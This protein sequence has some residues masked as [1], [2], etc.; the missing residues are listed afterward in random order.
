MR[1]R[2]TSSR[3]P[4]TQTRPQIPALI[5]KH[6]PVRMDPGHQKYIINS[7]SN[8]HSEMVSPKRRKSPSSRRAHIIP[9]QPESSSAFSAKSKSKSFKSSIKKLPLCDNQNNSQDFDNL[10][11]I[12]LSKAAM[13]PLSQA[14]ESFFKHHFNAKQVIVYQEIPNLQLLYSSALGIKM[15]HGSGLVGYTFFSR[16]I[17]RSQ[18]GALHPSFLPTVDSEICPNNSPIL[19]FPL[20]DWKN[21]VTYI[22]EIIRPT[23]APEFTPEDEEFVEWFTKKFKVLSRWLKPSSQPDQITTELLQFNKLDQFLRKVQTT[24]SELFQCRTFEIWKQDLTTDTLLRYNTDTSSNIEIINQNGAGIVGDC[25][26]RGQLVNVVLNKF[27][28]SYNSSIDGEENEAV[29]CLPVSESDGKR[30][31]ALVLRGPQSDS[32]FTKDDEEMLRRYAPIIL[33]GLSNSESLTV[34][35]RE[36]Q[37]SRIER[38]GLGA[39]LEVVEIISSQLDTEKLTDVIMEKGRLLTDADRCSLFLV[40]EQ[41]DRLITYLHQ[42]LENS[43]DL[44]IN[45]GIAGKTVM[46][47]KIFNIPDVYETDFFDSTT[48]R[49]SGYRTKS[50][51]S[52]PIYNNRGEVIGVTEMVNKKDDKPFTQ[53]DTKLIQIFNVFCGI[54]L[55]NARLYKESIEMSHEIRSFFD[56]AFAISHSNKSVQRVISDILQNAKNTIGASNASIFVLDDGSNSQNL[57]TFISDNELM[58][59]SIPLNKGIASMCVKTKE[60]YIVNDCYKSPLFNRTIDHITQFKSQSILA[61]PILSTE[62]KVLGV[63]EIVNKQK[64][65]F[66]KKDMLMLQAFSA[67][68]AIALENSRL[69]DIAQL[70]DAEIEMKKWISFNERSRTE[71]P[72]NLELN[73]EEKKKVISLNCFAVDF[74]GIGHFKELFYFFNM[75]KLLE[76]FKIT[77]ERFF[78]F[79]FVISSTYNQVPYHNWTHA[80]DVSQYVTYE[81][82]TAGLDKVFTSFELFGLLTAAICHD[83]NHEGLNNIYNVKA[84]T[85]FGILFKDQSV[86]EMHHITVAIPIITRDDINL[87]HSLDSDETKKMWNLFVK[88]I[89]ATDMAKHF[90]LVKQCQALNDEG[91]WSLEEPENR[92]LALQLLIK[93][94]DI[95]NVSRPFE[96]ANKWCDILNNEFFR[97]GDL[98]K[99]SGIGLTSPLNDR[100]H[101]DKPKSQIG[102]YNFICL[103]LYQV[104]ALIFPPLQVNVD[105]LKSNLEVWKSMVQQQPETEEKK[106]GNQQQKN[107]EKKEGNQ[108]QKN[109][110]SKP[111]KKDESDKK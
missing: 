84:E 86:M 22:I 51:L 90:A 9:P 91:K 66:I 71:I 54:S 64:G 58:P 31:F 102:F 59:P 48:D 69:K 87:F 81:I 11:D 89:L 95:S 29:L 83:A 73:D 18:N 94:A 20:W 40:N 111:E 36:Y 80:C 27:S 12:F 1:S 26:L 103:P 33:L 24:V 16:K 108:Q 105:S 107:E 41:R 7:E 55:E 110:E 56:T 106:E 82:V 45:K 68:A 8:P 34:L 88:L 79:I 92:T 65:E 72:T 52:V 35:D 19:L 42:G 78:R 101:S 44:P 21:N 23:L 10:I 47:A 4:Q 77:N 74:K 25:L 46:E 57:T 99:E 5:A 37:N 93:V 30:I 49:D 60:S 96:L 67:F 2:K 14:I 53:W 28:N 100:E 17:L 38:E 13:N 104:I 62:N 32:L 39:L 63:T 15:T 61:V 109:E 75:F 76:K 98:E 50:I 97:Q 70:G 6:Q 3:S 43:I 85:P